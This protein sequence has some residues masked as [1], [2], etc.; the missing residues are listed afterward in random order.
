VTSYS[1]LPSGPRATVIATWP[2]EWADHSTKVTTLSDTDQAGELAHVLARLSEGA[3]DA[4]AWLDIYPAIEAAISELIDQL[5]S[6]VDKIEKIYL[7][8]D[9]YRHSDQ[10]SFTDV[11]DLLATDYQR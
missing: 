6:P 4:A 5:R 9:G 11:K 10:W 3:W 7:P 2:G 8:K 1:V